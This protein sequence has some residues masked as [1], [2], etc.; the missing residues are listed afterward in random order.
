[1]PVKLDP[2]RLKFVDYFKWF[3]G[4]LATLW[5][6]PPTLVNG[7][8]FLNVT[9]DLTTQ[10]N[11]FTASSR[12]YINGVLDTVPSELDPYFKLVERM[13]FHWSVAGE[14]CLVIQDGIINTI[15]PDYVFPIRKKDNRDVIQGFYF[16]FPIPDTPTEVRVIEYNVVTG[17][18]FQSRRTFSGG[19]LSDATS[20]ESV[21]IQ[22]VLYE[23]TGGGYYGDI[24]GLVRELNIRYALLQLALNSTAIP[25]LQT[26][27]ENMGS[28]I[29]G[30]DGITPTK[31]AGLGKTGLG[32][33]VPPPFT[34]EEGAR[35]IERSGTGLEEAMAYIRIVLGSLA[36]LSGVPEYVY[37]ISLT[38]SANEVERVMFMGQSRI[39][40]LQRAMQ[41]TFAQLGISVEFEKVGIGRT[42]NAA[43][44]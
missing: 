40:R 31:V 12:F 32:L 2:I 37:G 10:F 14:Y 4:D 25:L 28:G 33:V 43:T 8:S 27:T 16:V 29:V 30:S 21:D 39:N 23:N 24:E 5:S 38:Q 1:M 18:A 44:E 41:N 19:Q 22:L 3:E 36:V 13:V 11:Y 6:I 42:N 9:N 7:M 34:G 15:R 17:K 20:G 35:Y 26:A